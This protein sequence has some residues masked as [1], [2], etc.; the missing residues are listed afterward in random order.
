MN[1]LLGSYLK[2]KTHGLTWVIL[3][4]WMLVCVG[5]SSLG[6]T[7]TNED[8]NGNVEYRPPEEQPPW[9]PEVPEPDQVDLA[10]QLIEKKHFDVALVQLR[11]AEKDDPK[12]AEILTLIGICHREEGRLEEAE[13]AFLKALNLDPDLASAH[14]GLGITLFDAGRTEEA[15]KSL[16]KTVALDPGRPDFQNNLGVFHLK[17]G[18]LAQAEK[19]FRKSLALAPNFSRA[20]NNLGFCLARSGRDSEAYQVFKKCLPPAQASNNLGVAYESLQQT[21]K[22]LAMYQK[23]VREAPDLVNAQDNL[24]RLEGIL[25][26]SDEQIGKLNEKPPI[27]ASETDPDIEPDKDMETQR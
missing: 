21:H 14:S 22:A 18:N 13:A 10:H 15:R 4:I 26:L 16:E 8:H 1:I 9:T 19:H 23:A 24:H 3:V 11:E 5:C 7:K 17:N 2:S 25:G 27:A 6:A 12:N 20:A